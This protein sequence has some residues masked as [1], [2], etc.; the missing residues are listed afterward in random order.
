MF[1][2]TSIIITGSESGENCSWASDV[3]LYQGSVPRLF[4]EKMWSLV[5]WTHSIIFCFCKNHPKRKR[6]TWRRVKT[7]SLV[8]I[9]MIPYFLSKRRPW[10]GQSFHS[11][12]CAS[13]WLQ[14]A[15]FS[16]KSLWA[17]KNILCIWV[18]RFMSSLTSG[19]AVNITQELQM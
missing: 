9:S 17:N 8:S 16:S 7:R 6:R 11:E 10:V 18:T 13:P 2:I 5:S 12:G 3:N 4:E 19:N 14:N 1:I 15:R